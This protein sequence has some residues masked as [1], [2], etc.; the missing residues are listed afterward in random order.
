MFRRVCFAMLR[1]QAKNHRL[2]L[3]V[4][5]NSVTAILH[6]AM[7]VPWTGLHCVP[8]CTYYTVLKPGFHQLLASEDAK[9]FLAF[10]APIGTFR[11]NVMPMGV[12]GVAP[13][14]CHDVE[15]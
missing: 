13:A 8:G 7:P 10:E 12:A 4:G 9:E 5:V 1:D 6:V 2:H 14:H 11:G 3:V 15:W